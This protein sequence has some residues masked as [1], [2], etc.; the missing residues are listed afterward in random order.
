[1]PFIVVPFSDKK[2][3]NI[4]SVGLAVGTRGENFYVQRAAH[5]AGFKKEKYEQ[6]ICWRLI[7]GHYR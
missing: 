6:S 1:M 3:L 7:L 4:S 5:A 2:E